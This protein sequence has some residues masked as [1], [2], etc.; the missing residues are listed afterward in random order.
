MG[1][2]RRGG[3]TVPTR[4]AELAILIAARAWT[5][6]F[7][8]Y[9]HE[10]QALAAGVDPKVVEAIKHRRP[11][12]FERDDEATIY[13]FA[14]ELLEKRAI[15]EP[16]YAKALALLGEQTLIDLVNLLGFYQFVATTLVAFGVEP[17]GGQLPLGD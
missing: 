15:S 6:Q 12:A 17:P 13:A 11:P 9:A 8:W 16:T 5:A 1:Y 4:L 10:P 7:A 2:M 3:M 14:T